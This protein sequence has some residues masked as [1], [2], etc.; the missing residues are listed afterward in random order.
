MAR[1]TGP[2]LRLSRR[3]GTDLYLKSGVRA[4]ESKCNMDSP[5]GVAA[6]ARREDFQITVFSL[7]KNKK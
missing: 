3:E 5:P 6:G 7:E 2:T 1:Y 4:I